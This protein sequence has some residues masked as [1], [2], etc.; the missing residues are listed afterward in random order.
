MTITILIVFVSLLGLI[1][2]HELGHFLLAR[3]F[4][5]KVEEFGIGL[6]PRIFGKKFGQTLYSLNLLPLGAFVRLYG[7]EKEATG[8]ESFSA[9]PI[10]Q[11]AIIIFAGVAAFW[12]ISFVI[13]SFV[14]AIWGIP[15]AVSD[16][17]NSR[18]ADIKIQIAA[19][20]PDSPA[21]AAGLEAGDTILKMRAFGQDLETDKIGQVQ[22]FTE[23]NKGQE[24]TLTIERGK[25]VLDVD[26]IPR[27]SAPEGEGAM[28]VALIGVGMKKYSWYK[29]PLAGAVITG[30]TTIAIPYMLSKAVWQKIRGEK[31]PGLELRG[32]VGIGQI[33]GR[34]V[35][36]GMGNFLYL[37]AVISIYLALFNILPIPVVDGGKL[38]FLGIEKLRGK[39]LNN[40]VEQ[41]VGA[42]FFA[43]LLVLMI[44]ITIKDIAK[45]F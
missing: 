42:F 33:M 11:K 44:W 5:V 37:V 1:V 23:I 10:W 16:N 14:A 24:V 25:E 29:A 19:V 32:P 35:E 30:E 20:A 26:L 34:A 39:P 45:L 21:E 27:V 9:K 13:L 28:G 18:L 2:L 3:K 8:P 17:E 38:M 6:P 40:K 22:A 15:T 12:I 4:G 43:L 31:V 7:E 36:Q 41:R